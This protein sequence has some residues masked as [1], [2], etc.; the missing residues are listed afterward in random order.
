MN[1]QTKGSNGQI[2]QQKGQ[3]KK[4]QHKRPR[5]QE[6]IVGNKEPI[7]R[8]TGTS[9]GRPLQSNLSFHRR[10]LLPKVFRQPRIA[11]TMEHRTLEEILPIGNTLHFKLPNLH[12][13]MYDCF[14]FRHS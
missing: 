10:L 1:D 11:S 14:Y 7:P 12:I 9:L 3:G 2:L 4:V 8:K 13:S 5:P 6:G